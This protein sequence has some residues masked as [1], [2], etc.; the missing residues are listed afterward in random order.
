MNISMDAIRETSC[1][2]WYSGSSKPIIWLLQR[3]TRCRSSIGTPTISTMT[4]SGSSAAMS[5]TKSQLPRAATA[6]T[7]LR[8]ISRMWTAIRF[9]TF[10]EKPRFTSRRKRVC[11]GAS[12]FSMIA[13]F[14]SSSSPSNSRRIVPPRAEEKVFESSWAAMTSRYL[15]TTQ[16]PPAAPPP[17]CQ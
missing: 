3:N 12:M 9:V 4:W 6:S 15:L 5:A 2:G 16:K 13:R 10:G 11:R 14:A 1:D 8:A 7:M 17:G